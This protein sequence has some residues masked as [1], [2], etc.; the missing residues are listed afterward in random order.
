MRVARKYEMEDKVLSSLI[1]CVKGLSGIDL[2]VKDHPDRETDSRKVIENGC[3]AILSGLDYDIAVQIA[4][5]P[6]TRS[7]YSQSAR[8]E[9]LKQHLEPLLSAQYPD[10][11]VDVVI[12]SDS[13]RKSF[14]PKEL[15]Q[16]ILSVVRTTDA[17]SGSD[18]YRFKRFTLGSGEEIDVCRFASLYPCSWL[19]CELND[20]DGLRDSFRYV[21]E[22]KCRQFNLYKKSHL[23]CV[24]LWSEDFMNLNEEIVIDAFKACEIDIGHIDSI[25]FVHQR[26][27]PLVYPIFSQSFDSRNNATYLQR[28]QWWPALGERRP[29]KDIPH[30]FGCAPAATLS[31]S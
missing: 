14:N 16:E 3:D 30:Q 25:W 26:S 17:N 6:I 24:V 19:R 2:I 9:N 23:L 20:S 21:I 1:G 10:Q 11:G 13:L 18:R 8:I 31:D 4:E 12:H 29:F 7:A 15:A 5:V 28:Y 27:V 22:K